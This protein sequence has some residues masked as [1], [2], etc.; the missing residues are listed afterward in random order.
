MLGTQTSLMPVK[1][2]EIEVNP[3]TYLI[4]ISDLT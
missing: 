3:F 4:D 2:K 1:K